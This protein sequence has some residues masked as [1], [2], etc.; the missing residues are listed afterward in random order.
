MQLAAYSGPRRENTEVI[1]GVS[2][3]HVSHITAEDFSEYKAAGLNTL[4]SGDDASYDY[5][6]V[7]KKSITDYSRMTER[8]KEYLDIAE[9]LHIPVLVRSNLIDNLLAGNMAYNESVHQAQIKTMTTVLSRYS[10]F[11]GYLAYDELS[12]SNESIP[13]IYS[14]IREIVLNV[15]PDAILYTSQLPLYGDF[16]SNDEYKAYIEKYSN[17]AGTFIYDFYP[18]LQ[19]LDDTGNTITGIRNNWFK[20]LELVASSAES[21]G[22]DAGIV[23]QAF[24]TKKKTESYGTMRAPES[25]ADISFQIYSAL[26]YGMKSISFYRYMEGWPS[27]DTD[28]LSSMVKYDESDPAKVVK[29]KVYGA[30]QSVNNEIKSIDQVL[31]NCDWQGTLAFSKYGATETSDLLKEVGSCLD[32]TYS[33]TRIRSVKATEEVI[34]GCLQDQGKRDVF[35]WVNATDPGAGLREECTI[36]FSDAH[37]AVIYQDGRK[38]I[39]RLE[40]G[41]CKLNLN[42]GQGAV[43]IPISKNAVK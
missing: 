28:C 14:K 11:K 9:E 1:D 8:M 34:A 35:V 39:V 27:E 40:N 13:E 24:A 32:K 19:K 7:S 31:M 17:A 16:G 37:L 26:A 2:V 12:A 23:V 33:N 21:N 22:Y 20:N 10:C 5:D 36:T 3:T 43:V 4:L 29:T 38:N 25:K 15:K 6:P 18:L 42:A 30:V 41:V